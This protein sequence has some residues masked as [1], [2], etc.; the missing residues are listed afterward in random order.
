MQKNSKNNIKEKITKGLLKYLDESVNAIYATKMIER[1]LQRH[2]FKELIEGDSWQ[3]D[4]GDRYYLKRGDSSIIAFELGDRSK[5]TQGFKI[6]GAHTDSPALKVKPNGVKE[7]K[8]YIQLAVESYGGSI[9]STWFDRDLS[10]A[11]RVTVLDKE[12]EL[13]N[14][15][16]D[17]KR[18][19]ATVPNVAIHLDHDINNGKKFNKQ[20]ELPPI[21]MQVES[22]KKDNKY[23]LNSILT[24]EI[25]KSYP[26]LKIEEVLDH[27][28][29]FYDFN[30]ASLIGLNQEFI[31]SS[32]IDN[33]L[34][35]YISL[36]AFLSDS[37]SDSKS[38][39][40]KMLLFFD[41]EECGS[42]SRL[43]A[44]SSFLGHTLERLL[45]RL[46]MKG[47]S[48]YQLLANSFL[49]SCDNAH[50]VHPNYP[51]KHDELHGPL[52][53][54]GPVIK[55]NVNQRYSTT[56]E[57]S[58]I[59]Q[60]LCKVSDIPVQKFV[61]RSDMRCGSTIGPIVSTKTGIKT[62]DVGVPTFAMH[63]IRELAGVDD[64]FYLYNSFIN[65]F[66]D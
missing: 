41:H 49:I 23:L 7:F 55:I 43:G 53:N 54:G 44:D 2:D 9:I 52:I 42:G 38:C 64:I 6:I 22:S 57:T 20:K 29:F 48:Y 51:D 18:A 21:I 32:R 37:N 12:G 24:D 14:C 16:I 1:E 27:D 25:K 35:C 17:F 66:K 40:N 33:L 56:S 39:S 3:V 34:S 31:A 36:Q 50:A 10:L 28:L 15:Y 30:K 8:N 4:K 59:F 62:V 19:I 58:A 26:K 45:I 46:G 61:V 5:I 11:G 65:F 47:E 13:Q 60:R 63:S